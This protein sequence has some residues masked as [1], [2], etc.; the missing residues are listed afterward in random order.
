M[1]PVLHDEIT[2]NKVTEGGFEL[3]NF[4]REYHLFDLIDRK[5]KTYIG[6]VALKRAISAYSASSQ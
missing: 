3:S 6:A 2:A 5:G 4:N 1:L